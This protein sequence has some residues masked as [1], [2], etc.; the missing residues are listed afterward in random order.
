MSDQAE[1]TLETQSCLTLKKS[2]T[3]AIHKGEN[4]IE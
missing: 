3:N 1:L 4:K 2:I